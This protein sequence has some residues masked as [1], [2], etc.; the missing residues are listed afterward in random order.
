[1]KKLNVKLILYY[2]AVVIFIL[3]G[4]LVGKQERVLSGGYKVHYGERKTIQTLDGKTIKA[5]DY[6]EFGDYRIVKENGWY[7]FPWK[8]SDVYL[9]GDDIETAVVITYD[10][11]KGDVPNVLFDR[12]DFEGVYYGIVEI[13]V[14][15][16][17]WILLAILPLIVSGLLKIKKKGRVKKNLKKINE[18][19]LMKAQGIISEEE[20]NLKKS[21]L[22]E[23]TK[24]NM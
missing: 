4:F 20:Y 3:L 11:I 23:K 17:I 8:S 6:M 21:S 22:V 14:S 5:R 24:E 18:L 10:T 19:E 9:V 7:M 2:V 12:E 1:M 15:C 16:I 13:I